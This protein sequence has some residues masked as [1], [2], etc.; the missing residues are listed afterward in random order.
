MLSLSMPALPVPRPLAG[1]LYLSLSAAA[2][3]LAAMAYL[4]LPFS[5]LTCLL[6]AAV[7]FGVYALNRFTDLREDF[8]NDSHRSVF[9][10]RNQHLLAVVYVIL[11][12][13]T[14]ALTVFGWLNAYF[15]GLLSVGVLYSCRLVPWYSPKSGWTMTRLK[16]LPLVKNVLVAALWGASVFAV[17]LLTCAPGVVLPD[18]TIPAVLAAALTLSTLNNTVFCDLLDIEG[19]RVAGN[20]TLPVVA[21]RTATLRMLWW[22]NFAWVT[23]AGALALRGILPATH[24]VFLSILAVYPLSYILPYLRSR[25]R[26]QALESLCE[27]DLLLFAVG[28]GVLCWV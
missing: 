20:R 7:V 11:G 10:A 9:F 1:L 27:A 8:I 15:V 13:V 17:P 3:V 25:L 28:L 24:V 21:G 14:V 23:T 19:D 12:A 22:V 4:R 5:L 16:E 6:S 2:V 18:L 26:R